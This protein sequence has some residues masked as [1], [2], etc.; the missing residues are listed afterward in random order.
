M[1]LTQYS[2]ASGCGCKMAPADLE[3]L[4]K[5]KKIGSF[6][7]L[8]VGNQAN[9]DA[10]VWDLGKGS[11]LV[12]TVDFFM[13]IVDDP[14]DFGRIAATNAISDVYAM[15]AKPIFAN[16]ILGWPVDLL[17]IELAAK[18]LEGAQQ[19]CAKA[20]IP[21]AG[22]HSIDSKEP[23]FGLAVNGLVQTE[24]LKRN[25]TPKLGDLLLLTKPIGTGIM[26][27]AIRR[28][29]DKENHAQLVINE[30]CKLNSLGADI[31]TVQ[32]VNALTDVTGFG[33]LGHL[34]EMCGEQW[35]AE[36]YTDKIP[37]FEFLQTYLDLNIIPDNTYRNWNAWD[38]KVDGA[39]D[40]KWFQLLND[41][42]T[43]GGLLIA[44]SEAAYEAVKSLMLQQGL[45]N[46]IQPIG[47]ITERNST[48]VSVK[49]MA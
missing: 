20:G 39:M 42:Q 7:S 35:S 10:A 45:E 46:Y 38:K 36:I 49:T 11:A 26:G 12:S 27:T 23:I 9:D 5:D 2:H 37:H 31:A 34:I 3:K 14:F 21:L 25:S 22:G 44:V 4:L 13:P 30:M 16:A 19:I 40:M 41:P 29:L 43:S 28:G 8:L 17:P 33:L 32:G 1:K 18:V 48:V 47:K 15:G 24:N 6:D